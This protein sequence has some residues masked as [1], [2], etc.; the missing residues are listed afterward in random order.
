MAQYSMTPYAFVLNPRNARGGERCKI[1]DVDGAG[2]TVRSVLDAKL[3]QLK[4]DQLYVD[5]DDDSKFIRVTRL[6]VYNDF[7]F[8]EFG[9]ARSG[10]V[11][12][13]HQK[14]GTRV[15]Y[16][17]DEA[18]ETLIRGIFAY[19][20]GAHEAYWLSERAGN[21][22]AYS[23]MQ[24]LLQNAL[25]AAYAGLTVKVDP[26]ADWAAVRAW[27]QQVLVQ[28]IRF[29]APHR[30]GSTQAIDVNGLRADVRVT[31]KPRGLSLNRI[32]D[33][34]GPKREDVY[35]FLSG[36]PLVANSGATTQ[37][38]I[39]DGWKAKVAFRN[40]SG[41]QRSFGLQ[42]DEG[43]PTLIYPVGKSGPGVP[44]SYRPTDHE[45]GVSC[46]EFLSDVS[47]RLPVGVN[48]PAEVLK[49]LP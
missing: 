4:G 41:R 40:P 43:A 33:A 22:S 49:L 1:D 39:G 12:T 24:S 48:L 25:R 28:E 13:L 44:R 23:S 29:D 7:T 18:N 2:G 17:A 34:N 6:Y 42:A 27:A 21:A 10:Y 47:G 14:S 5:P 35:G 20:A 36:A 26:V 19:P 15:S 30:G 8:V 46:A 11:G 38:V 9:T 32:I 16:G 45:F 37:S 3:T 31:V